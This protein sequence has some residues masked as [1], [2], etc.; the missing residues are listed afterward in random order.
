MKKAIKPL[1]SS[2][3]IVLL[4]NIQLNAQGWVGNGGNNLNAVNSSLANVPINIGIG[5]NAP[6]AQLHTTGSLRFANLGIA[7]NINNVL[8]TDAAGNVF[9]RDA[10]TIGTTNAWL[11]NGNGGTT[12]ANF[13]GTT[14]PQS[15]SF[16]TNNTQRMTINGNTG[17][18]GIGV[19]TPQV[20]LH[21]TSAAGV[22]PFAYE[23]VVVERGGDM[24]LGIYSSVAN[25]TTGGASVW[26]GHS[27]ATNAANRFPGYEMQYGA[28]TNAN[29]G[30]NYFL[31]FNYAERSTLN[32]LVTNSISNV[33]VLDEFGRVG[34]NLGPAQGPPV[35]PAVRFHT[36][37]QVRHQGLLP[38][39]GSNLVIDGNGDL[40][41]GRTLSSDQVSELEEL[42]EEVKKLK[43]DIKA[44][45]EIANLPSK[46]GIKTNEGLGSLLYQNAPN[47]FDQQ[48]TIRYSIRESSYK[49]GSI[50][51]TNLSGIVLKRFDLNQQQDGTVVVNAGEMS[52]G[53][54]V[55]SLIVN[56]NEISSKKMILTR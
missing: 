5:T 36:N 38:G 35:L 42:K 4:L 55:Y 49:N 11:L 43:E 23:N 30:T 25:A 18:V 24:K 33:M 44:L 31:R 10:A 1:L 45:K 7:N 15:L 51:I 41:I 50:V 26:L 20:L 8:V 9:L 54:Y 53:T 19:A 14:D 27:Q 28:L 29:N 3:I 46:T 47:P 39:T 52:A 40:W 56:G 32:G 6:T 16:R 12:A 34:F 13:L 21:V 2:V 48:T 17:F 37:G 22:M